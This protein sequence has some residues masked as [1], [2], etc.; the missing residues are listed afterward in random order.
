MLEWV[1][2]VTHRQ[3]VW[4]RRCCLLEKEEEEEEMSKKKTGLHLL[5][6]ALSIQSSLH[7]SLSSSRSIMSCCCHLVVWLHII[8]M[9]KSVCV[10]NKPLCGPSTMVWLK[11]GVM[12]S[13]CHSSDTSLPGH[14]THHGHTMTL[15]GAA[16]ILQSELNL[17]IFPAITQM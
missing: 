4:W 9:R 12:E 16:L 17:P 13:T 3:A 1:W 2:W 14:N 6:E 11:S 5:F 10:V 15:W 8:L 7:S